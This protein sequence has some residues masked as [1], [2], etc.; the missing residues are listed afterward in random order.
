ME[1]IK[2][3]SINK[4]KFLICLDPL[5][6][7]PNKEKKLGTFFAILTPSLLPKIRKSE[8]FL[9]GVPETKFGNFKPHSEW[10][11]LKSKAFLKRVLKLT[12][13]GPR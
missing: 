5:L 1:A 9:G 10:I 13:K 8:H 12:Q 7:P 3:K 4:E 2:K 11:P 6:L